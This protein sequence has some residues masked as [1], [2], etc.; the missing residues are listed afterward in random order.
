VAE[1][2]ANGITFHVQRL[3]RSPLATPAASACPLGPANPTVVFVHGL[4]IDN[5][6][7][8]YYSLGNPVA[9]AGADAILYDLRGHGRSDLT[10]TGYRLEDSV[11]DLLALVRALG[12]SEPVHLVGHSYGASVA[13]R[14]AID[15]AERIASVLLIE[16]HCAESPDGGSWVEDVVDTLTATAMCCE[17]IIEPDDVSPSIQRK[18]R[19]LRSTNAFLNASTLIEDVAAA[20]AFTDAELA[21]VEVPAMALYGEHTDL[22][23][24]VAK[25]ARAMPRCRLEIFPGV[26]HS[27]LRDATPPVLELL[28]EWLRECSEPALERAAS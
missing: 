17:R 26:G 14:A 19:G 12:V 3:G 15:H 8:L 6:S 24:S 25:L 9:Q 22:A 4:F 27:V 10:P 11:E 28:V 23:S 18:L 16:P 2:A 5:L 7:S 21:A 20:P 13:L 1:I